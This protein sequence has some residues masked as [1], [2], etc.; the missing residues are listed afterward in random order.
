M[1]D[2]AAEHY[3][4]KAQATSSAAARTRLQKFH[5]EAK[6]QLLTTFAFKV[7][8][9]LDLAC[10]RG[11]DVHKWRAMCIDVVKGLDVSVGSIKEA[12]TRAAGQ[13]RWDFEHV[14]LKQGLWTD[15]HVYD[16]VSCFFALHY[17]F[18]TEDTAKMLMETVATS[19]KPG[20]YFFGIVAS[21]RSVLE[22]FKHADTYDNGCVCMRT[23]W[24]GPPQC[25]GS[26]Y[27]CSVKD[28]VTESSVVPEYLVFYNVLDTLAGAHGLVRVPL[29]EKA[30]EKDCAG[31]HAMCP[32]YGGAEAECTRLYG[33]FAFQKNM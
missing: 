25:F 13:S 27:T 14:D 32:P 22:C 8:R 23:M 16:A 9:L 19:L 12:R 6:R 1:A 3:D 7:P 5:N 29:N 33:A 28:T 26:A 4:A 20:G 31:F 18:E 21:G 30:F 2:T 24:E 11:G 17:F 10:G 15:G